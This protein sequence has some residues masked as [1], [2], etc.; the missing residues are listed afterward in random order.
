M[1]KNWL[2]DNQGA[3]SIDGTRVLKAASPTN[4]LSTVQPTYGAVVERDPTSGLAK[5]TP[6]FALGRRSCPLPGSWPA[7]RSRV[8]PQSMTFCCGTWRGTMSTLQS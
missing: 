5:R 2:K 6:I 8:S 1:K 4:Q 7:E 3:D